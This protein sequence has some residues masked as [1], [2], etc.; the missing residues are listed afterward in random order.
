MFSVLCLTKP[1]FYVRSASDK[2][3]SLR[4]LCVRQS[5]LSTFRSCALQVQE[6]VTSQLTG[7]R[8]VTVALI[9]GVPQTAIEIVEGVNKYR[10]AEAM[11]M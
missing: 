1:S 6:G 11:A 10:W 7:S 8:V 4:L 9:N 5:L 3:S 2:N